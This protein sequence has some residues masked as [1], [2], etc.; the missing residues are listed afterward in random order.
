MLTLIEKNLQ[1]GEEVTLVV[2][3]EWRW[4]TQPNILCTLVAVLLF[5]VV[6][7]VSFSLVQGDMQADH[8][9]L[10]L[11]LLP[12]W[13]GGHWLGHQPVLAAQTRKTHVLCCDH[14]SCHCAAPLSLSVGARAA[15]LA[16]E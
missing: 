1:P 14:S 2:L 12:F 4:L 11:A 9:S 15:H 13:G 8:I 16:V 3:P 10:L 6:G 5:F 7:K